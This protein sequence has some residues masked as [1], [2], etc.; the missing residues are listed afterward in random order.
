MSFR[1][2]CFSKANELFVKRVYV[3]SCQRDLIGGFIAI[4]LMPAPKW[5]FYNPVHDNHDFIKK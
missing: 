1:E 3:D 4:A 5:H 2:R